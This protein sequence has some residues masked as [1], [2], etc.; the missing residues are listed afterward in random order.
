VP[1]VTAACA[2]NLL[3]D[4]AGAEVLALEQTTGEWGEEP[5]AATCSAHDR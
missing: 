3:E 1:G 4:D 2:T 5:V